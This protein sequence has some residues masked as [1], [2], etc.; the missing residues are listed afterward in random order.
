MGL[1]GDYFAEKTVSLKR[2]EQ[3]TFQITAATIRS[4]CEF[5]LELTILDNGKTLTQEIKNGSEPFRVSAVKTSGEW[6]SPGIYRSYQALYVGGV[7]TRDGA[8]VRVNPGTYDEGKTV[9]LTRRPPGTAPWR[10]VNVATHDE[11]R[12]GGQQRAAVLAGVRR[13]G[14]GRP[15]SPRPQPTHSRAVGWMCPR[16]RQSA[17]WATNQQAPRRRNASSTCRLP[18]SAQP[19]SRASR[20]PWSWLGS[21]SPPLSGSAAVSPV[22]EVTNESS[23]SAARRLGGDVACLVFAWARRPGGR[24]PHRRPS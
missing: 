16:R 20:P 22:V 23:L 19:S 1:T 9:G 24:V 4:Y 5:T 2:G 14:P 3:Q 6:G 7:A 10:T 12:M 11:L 15:D 13:R 8:F 17:A 18:M 21:T